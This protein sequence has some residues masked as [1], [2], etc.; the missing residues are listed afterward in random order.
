MAGYLHRQQKGELNNKLSNVI[1]FILGFIFTTIIFLKKLS[2]HHNSIELEFQY[3]WNDVMKSI[4][5]N[6]MTDETIQTMMFF[7]KFNLTM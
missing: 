2:Y 4:F 5:L 3:T 7:E 1:L 6:S